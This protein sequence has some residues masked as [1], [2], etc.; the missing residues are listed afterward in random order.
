MKFRIKTAAF[1]TFT[2]WL[3]FFLVP[4]VLTGQA[5]AGE[6]GRVLA[7]VQS[8]APGRPIWIAFYIAPEEGA[9]V[10]WVDQTS[11][12]KGLHVDLKLPDGFSKGQLVRP[13]PQPVGDG[14]FGYGGAFWALQEIL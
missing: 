7:E 12:D 1:I 13:A 10:S 4:G 8:I 5:L 2:L 6:Q 9:Y 14:V 11:G 3:G